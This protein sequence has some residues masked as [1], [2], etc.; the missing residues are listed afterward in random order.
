[1]AIQTSRCEVNRAVLNVT[2]RA[3]LLTYALFET[4][5]TFRTAL[6]TSHLEVCIAIRHRARNHIIRRTVDTIE[7]GH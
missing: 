1:M 6:F 4:S 3:S 5:V 2:E 7:A